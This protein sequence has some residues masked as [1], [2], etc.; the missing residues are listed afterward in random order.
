MFRIGT[1]RLGRSAPSE[2]TRARALG[3]ESLEVRR[4]LAVF[5]VNSTGNDLDSYLDDGICDTANNP[6]ADPPIPP[7]GI[8]TL[9]AAVAQTNFSSGQDSIEFNIA[10]TGPHT[11]F[12]MRSLQFTDSIIL[13]GTTQPGFAG[14]PLIELDGSGS[15]A[16][17]NGLILSGDS[18]VRGMAVNRFPIS[19]IRV[20]GQ[21]NRIEGNY[22]GI[23]VSGTLARGNGASTAGG[24][25]GIL[26]ANASNNTI[27][28]TTPDA[29][30][31]ISSNGNAGIQIEGGN[32]NVVQGNYIGTDA[33]GSFTDPDGVPESGDE[34]GNTVGV[35]IVTS[36]GGVAPSGNLIG[37]TTPAA[38]NII[39][40]SV[41]NHVRIFGGLGPGRSRTR[42]RA[43]SWGPIRAARFPWEADSRESSSLTHPITRSAVRKEPRR[44]HFAPEPAISSPPVGLVVF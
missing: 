24:L 20:S 3:I 40:G 8:C 41:F 30:N 29:R 1:L 39:A 36:A 23:D 6:L 13:D 42:F 27:G 43:T 21:N 7:S 2:H 32:N 9:R 12:P 15:F 31:I 10:G 35:V 28:G 16:D 22:I 5:T 38:R 37:G 18:V 44:M 19:G 25:G 4:M 33:T 11:I 26:L 34:L 17:S 14:T